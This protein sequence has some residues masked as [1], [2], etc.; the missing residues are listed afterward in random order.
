MRI[1]TLDL[2]Y[3]CPKMN[4]CELDASTRNN[5][6]SCRYMRCIRAGMSRERV[7]TGA[8]KGVRGQVPPKQKWHP[9]I[10]KKGT[11]PYLALPSMGE[12]PMREVYVEPHIHNSVEQIQPVSSYQNPMNPHQQQLEQQ[13][14]YYQQAF[15][16]PNQGSYI[17]NKPYEEYQIYIEQQQQ[18]PAAQEKL[19]GLVDQAQSVNYLPDPMISHQQQ[20]EH[21]LDYYQAFEV[22]QQESY[23]HDHPH[24]LVDPAQPVNF[25]LDPIN[26]HQQQLEDQLD[27]DQQAFEAPQQESYIYG[28]PHE[29]YRNHSEQQHKGLTEQEKLVDSS[30]LI[31]ETN[32]SQHILDRQL[33]TP[34]Y[35][36][37]CNRSVEYHHIDA[38]T[39]DLSL[40]CPDRLA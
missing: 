12:A 35:E 22:P 16:I 24:S 11:F 2:K 3:S 37:I 20:H 30:G 7:R 25:Y 19:C 13:L 23:I 14:D 9:K 40:S 10:T 21:H 28:Q 1:V 8:M 29:E 38:T 31:F 17:Y 39:S 4:K 34:K 5:C 33:D 26:S 27:Y 15:E 32:R 36:E 6:R 18:G